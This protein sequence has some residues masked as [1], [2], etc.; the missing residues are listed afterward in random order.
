MLIGGVYDARKEVY[1]IL[2]AEDEPRISAFM[3]KGLKRAGFLTNVVSDGNVALD[4]I[5]HEKFDLL[6]LD[7]G[8]PAKDGK[9][10]LR[11][12]RLAG[13]DLIVIVVTARSIDPQSNEMIYTYADD[14]VNKP[15]L[16]RDLIQKM[17]SLL[18]NT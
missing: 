7:L 9:E 6:L 3:E 13:L 8:L 16:M 12:L 4:T 17:Q 15:F 11:E 1:R 5:L 14:V 10:I 2:I 18:R